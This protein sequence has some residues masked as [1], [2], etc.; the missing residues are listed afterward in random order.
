[1]TC[2]MRDSVRSQA[3]LPRPR[4]RE[5]TLQSGPGRSAARKALVL[6]LAGMAML[7]LGVLVGKWLVAGL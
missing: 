7:V 1:M 3:K 5:F 6:A 2:G 4:F